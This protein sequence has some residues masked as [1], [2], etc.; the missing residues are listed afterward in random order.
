MSIHMWQENNMTIFEV[1]NLRSQFDEKARSLNIG[2]DSTVDGL[3]NFI[4]NGAK[5]SRFKTGYNEALE[6]AKLI[7]EN[8]NETSNLSSLCRQKI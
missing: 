3:N 7:I 6:I 1:L 2:I 4:A 5:K 8:Y